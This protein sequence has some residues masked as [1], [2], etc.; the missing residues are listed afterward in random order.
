MENS[1]DE[2]ARE[3]IGALDRLMV[4]EFARLDEALGR[5]EDSV[6]SRF[7]AGNEFRSSLADVQTEM[8]TR[9][10]LE[11]FKEEYRHAHSDLLQVV[12]DL[13]TNIAVGPVELAQLARSEALRAGRQQGI[14]VSAN[15]LVT[16]VTVLLSACG[17]IAAIIIASHS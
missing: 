14:G 11:A 15:V 13:R 5:F 8:A 7:V 16:A 9:R 4:S 10:E 2:I 6:A 3:R 17:V 12:A 1:A